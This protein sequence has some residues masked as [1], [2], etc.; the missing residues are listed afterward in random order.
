[1][2]RPVNGI[3]LLFICSESLRYRQ[4]YIATPRIRHHIATLGLVAQKAYLRKD[5]G[6]SGTPQHEKSGLFDT[7]VDRSGRHTFGV[8]LLKYLR[9]TQTTL[10]I[11][12]LHEGEQYIRLGRRR[13]ETVIHFEIVVL[14]RDNAILAHGHVHVLLS[15]AGTHH[16]CLVTA[17]RRRSG[18]IDVYGYEQIGIGIVG[19]TATVYQS[20]GRI[21]ATGVH[22]RH[23]GETPL[24]LIAHRQSHAQGYVFLPAPG[25]IGPRIP[26]AVSGIDH[27]FT[28]GLSAYPIRHDAQEGRHSPKQEHD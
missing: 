1:M 4:G 21:G 2:F 15:L 23:I 12:V 3:H 14:V 26:P 17:R 24:Y 28:Y 25:I 27:H 8:L 10:E 20:H 6:R 5:T 7:A 18:G 19:L 22:H 13:I 9:E 11:G 16:V